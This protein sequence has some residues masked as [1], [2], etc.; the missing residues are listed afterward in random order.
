MESWT[1]A[2]SITSNRPAV[3]TTQTKWSRYRDKHQNNSQAV[4]ED[5]QVLADEVQRDSQP[6]D[7][8][9]HIRL[10]A[11]G[12]PVQYVPQKPV[13]FAEDKRSGLASQT[14]TSYDKTRQRNET[15][16]MKRERKLRVKEERRAA[17]AA[18]K[19]SRVAFRQATKEADKARSNATLNPSTP[20][21]SLS[22]Q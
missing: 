21:V 7:A 17:R 9:A 5:D 2:S 4:S 20:V 12:M 13:E 11:E 19:Q 14:H 15:P 8:L 18:K 6:Y 10:D 22:G 1:A 16:E 3:L